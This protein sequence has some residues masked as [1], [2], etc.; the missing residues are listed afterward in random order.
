MRD[1]RFYYATQWELVWWRF[2]KHKLAMIAAVFIILLYLSAIFADF[3]AP[4]TATTRFEGMQ[5]QPPSTIYLYR[6]GTGITGPFIYKVVRKADPKTFKFIFTPDTSK[7]IPIQFFVK[8]EPYKILGFISSDIHIFGTG[9]GNPAV[10]LFGTDRLGRDLF[11]RTLFGAQVS[12]SIGLIGVLV[13][14]MLGVIL[15]GVSGYMGGVADEI[16]Q[17]TIDFLLSLP[18]LPLWMA[19]SAALP[20]DWPVVQTYFA[21]TM[22]LSVIGWAGLARVVRGKLLQLREEDYA[23][24]AQA[25]GASKWRIIT[26]HLLPGFTSHLIVS[27]TVSIPGVILG[28][29]ALSFIGVGMQPPAVSWGTLLQDAQNIVAVAQQQWLMLP[30]LFV[31]ATVLLFNFV[32][33]GLR[34][35]ADPY[36]R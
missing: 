17:R 4:Y 19:L 6:E 1:E 11:S 25:A 9:K 10:H 7:P 24:A 36:T 33:D 20:R 32:G 13:S 34:D 3:M 21:I 15:G 18:T 31:V 26:R 35:A 30:A 12:L 5:Q 22:I 14:F 23:L 16:I 2:K 29:T 8:G 27:I 28:E